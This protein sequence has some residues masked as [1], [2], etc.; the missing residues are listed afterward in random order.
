MAQQR[1]AKGSSAD[2]ATT[3]SRTTRAVHAGVNP[4]REGKHMKVELHPNE[5]VVTREDGDKRYYGTRNAAGESNLL[6][7]IKN[8]LNAQGFDFIKK[9]MWKDGHMVDDMQQY[10]RERD[11]KGKC[12]AIYNERFAIEGINDVLN[13]EGVVTL[14]VANVGI[15]SGMMIS[16]EECGRVFD[17]TDENDA[18]EF[19]DG[20]D[21]EVEDDGK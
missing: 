21:C 3:T 5:C 4:R 17:L 9:R 7:A 18:D 19:T 2:R 1:R 10:L 11:T 6:W 20:H 16:C 8:E 14:V 15:W 12:L 13:R